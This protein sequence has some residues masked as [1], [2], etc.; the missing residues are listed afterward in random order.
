MQTLR[1]RDRRRAGWPTRFHVGAAFARRR[2]S[3]QQ[4]PSAPRRSSIP[5]AAG[6]NPSPWQPTPRRRAR[7]PR[8]VEPTDEKPAPRCP[9]R[10]GPL[11][12]VVSIGK[13]TVTVYDDGKKIAKSPISSGMS[14]HPTPTGI[15]TILEKNRYHYSNLYGGA[16]M[17]FMQ[18][19]TNS[20]VA[21][22]AGR[23]CRA[24]P[25]RMAA[26]VCPTASRATCSASP[27]SAR[28]SSSPTRT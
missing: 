8:Y 7:V 9:S 2:C 4:R 17:P 28:A 23:S 11:V 13:Q 16:P 1:K 5:G 25:P 21:M 24:I 20:G 3:L 22:H 19:V 6:R 26:S 27:T 15:F 10:R 12:I 18:R 14:G